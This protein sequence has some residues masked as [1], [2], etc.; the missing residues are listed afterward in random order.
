MNQ[1]MPLLL[2]GLE[3]LGIPFEKTDAISTAYTR[4]RLVVPKTH[5]NDA[6]C[7]GDPDGIINIPEEVTIIQSTGHGKRQ[8]LST[9]SLYGTP[10]YKV[11][12]EG[13]NSPYRAYCRLPRSVQGHMTMPGH[14]LRQKRVKGITS[15]DLIRYTHP[16]DGVVTGYATIINRNTRAQADSK[17]SIKLQAVTLLQ[18]NNGY[19]YSRGLNESPSRR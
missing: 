13:R 5:A 17:H 7:L 12:P 15:R 9:P 4:K 18:R 11:G 6:A 14:K 16:Q 10:R 2:D 8:M 3:K 1:L 19:R